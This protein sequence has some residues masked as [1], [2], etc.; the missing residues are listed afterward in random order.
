MN[1]V[2]RIKLV[3]HGITDIDNGDGDTDYDTLVEFNYSEEETEELGV[4]RI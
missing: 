1:K 2:A 3:R 4:A